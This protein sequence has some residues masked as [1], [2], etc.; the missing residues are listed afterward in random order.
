MKLETTA[1]LLERV[2]AKY[3]VSWWKLSQVLHTSE[4][5]VN[6]W[7]RGRST[8]SSDYALKIA[9]ILEEAPEYVLA[10]VEAERTQ[11]PA[12]LK[13]WQRIAMKF[14]AH[15]ASILLA[16]LALI[17]LSAPAPS[18]AY[19]S[20]HAEECILSKIR[21][22]LWQRLRAWLTPPSLAIVTVAAT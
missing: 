16:A 1:E 8:L 13:V 15:A 17:G 22:V 11:S 2:R 19:S 12:V 9:Q 4:S 14:R 18:E 3:G 21:R 20:A 10:C 7:K 5:T 6:N